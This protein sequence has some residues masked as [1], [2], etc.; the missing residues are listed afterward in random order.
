MNSIRDSAGND[1]RAWLRLMQ[2]ELA[3]SQ[4]DF[5]TSLAWR[6]VVVV[7]VIVATI[8]VLAPPPTG[9]IAKPVHPMA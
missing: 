7:A 2:E 4:S 9:G 8:N 5:E 1:R 6:L 3:P